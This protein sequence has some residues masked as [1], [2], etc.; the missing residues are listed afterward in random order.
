MPPP[1]EI[2]KTKDETPETRVVHVTAFRDPM[3]EMDKLHKL[4]DSLM[5]ARRESGSEVVPFH[6]FAA[7]VKDQV[8]KIREAGSSE[9]AFR[10]AIAQ[11]QVTFTARGLKG[12][13]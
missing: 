3:K 12:I 9:V 6:K 4:Y 11:G 2:K 8:T 13:D 1:K 5:D 7:L 10:V